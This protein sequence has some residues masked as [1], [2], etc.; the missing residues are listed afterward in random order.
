[1][2]P[3]SLRSTLAVALSAAVITGCA[4]QPAP[5]APTNYQPLLAYFYPDAAVKEPAAGTV[6]VC[7]FS[8]NSEAVHGLSADY[9][10]A[11]TGGG[12]SRG[13]LLYPTWTLD[14]LYCEKVWEAAS[15]SDTAVLTIA[16]VADTDIQ[17]DRMAIYQVPSFSLSDVPATGSVQV[18]ATATTGLMIKFFNSEATIPPPPPAEGGQGCTPGF[19]KRPRHAVYWTAPFTPATRFATVFGSTIFG[20]M[21][22]E[23]VLEEGGGR[24]KALGRHAVAALLN[25]VSP[26][27][28]YDL[29]STQV[30]DE[31]LAALGD[32]DRVR[33]TKDRFERFNEQGCPLKK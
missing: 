5:V 15:P 28:S 9:T 3:V 10:A 33:T 14:Y 31:F 20:T 13:N 24:E 25:S 17:L 7:N 22:L 26:G 8:T 18:R 29:T 19:W 27:V 32:R 21:T 23:D 1:M 16:Q 11:L 2:R 30:R 6:V 4:D 12:A